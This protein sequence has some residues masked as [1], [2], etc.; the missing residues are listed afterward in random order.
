MRCIV[1]DPPW[2]MHGAGPLRG[3][4]HFFDMK[5]QP[6]SKPMPYPT[7]TLKQIAALPVG[8]LAEPDA[9]LYLWTTS[10]FLPA[11]FEVLKA[12]RFR[13]STTLVWA[14]TPIGGG[15]GGCYG[16]ATEFVLFARRGRL[17]TTAKIP[18]NWWNCWP[19]E[20][21]GLGKPMHSA[22]PEPFFDL[23][24]QAS[25]GPYLE[26]FARGAGRLGW[27]TWGDEAHHGDRL[28]AITDNPRIIRGRKG[29]DIH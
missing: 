20:Y 18:R 2:P 3:R 9:H 24:T 10:G 4:E 25:P 21:N 8:D 28:V 27:D 5:A 12:W 29:H 19:R 26:L 16:I 17:A 13:Y 23:V 22:K 6:A 7:M 11:A 15:M 14:K 1:V